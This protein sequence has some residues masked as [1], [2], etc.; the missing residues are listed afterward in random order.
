MV[1]SLSPVS[2]ILRVRIKN[3]VHLAPEPVLLLLRWYVHCHWW[4][5][6]VLNQCRIIYRQS[7]IQKGNKEVKLIIWKQAEDHWQIKNWSPLHL[8]WNTGLVPQ[9]SIAVPSSLKCQW[10]YCHS[11]IHSFNN[12]YLSVCCLSVIDLGR[13]DLIL[14]LLLQNVATGQWK[15]WLFCLNC[16]TL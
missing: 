7:L 9:V 13:N 6:A 8:W 16:G 10:S 3:P 15:I 4:V 1:S 12:K 5:F 2:L 11:S 14:S